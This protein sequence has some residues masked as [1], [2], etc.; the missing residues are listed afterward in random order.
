MHADGSMADF[1][2][3]PAEEHVSRRSERTVAER[4]AF[5]RMRG[6]ETFRWRSVRWRDSRAV[7]ERAGLTPRDLNFHPHQANRRIIDA[8]GSRWVARGQVYVNI[9]RV[10]NTSAPRSRW[11]WTRQGK[12]G[13]RAPGR[14]PPVRAFGTGLTWGAASASGAGEGPPRRARFPGQG[15]QAVGMDAPA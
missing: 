15:S 1:I 10:G 8:V 5:I 3:V 4:T 7:L 12:E 6:N 11:R 13:S 9:E 14:Q 2:Y